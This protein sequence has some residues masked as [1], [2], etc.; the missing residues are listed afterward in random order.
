MAP[1]RKTDASQEGKVNILSFFK[2][3]SQQPS[4]A[5]QPLPSTQTP[6]QISQPRSPS[7]Q[8]PS[9]PPVQKTPSTPRHH[10][11][12]IGASDDE[13]GSGSDGGFSDDS[14]EDLSAILG[15]ARPTVV[16]TPSRNPYA[17]PRSKRTAVEFYSSPLTLI[18][19]HKFDLAALTSDARQDE[20]TLASSLK[21][22]AMTESARKGHGISKAGLLEATGLT[23]AVNEKGGHDAHKVLRAVQRAEPGQ[24]HTRYCFFDE[25][26][27]S[28]N[29]MPAPKLDNKSP[30]RLLTRA[31]VAAREQ[32]LVSGLPQ[33]I[34]S[35][36]G[37]MPDTLFEWI[38]DELCIQN[39]SLMRQEYCS[40]VRNCP[41][42][43][44]RLLSPQKLEELL[45]RLGAKQELKDWSSELNVQKISSDPYEARDWSCLVSFLNLVGEVA[46]HLSIASVIYAAQAC[47]KLSMDR[48]SLY[49]IDILTAYEGAI[50]RLTEIIPSSSWNSFV[51]YLPLQH[52]Y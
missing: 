52:R 7:P 32:H 31:T 39:S 37:S 46:R 42:Q 16:A 48:L 6:P 11:L 1:P 34:L 22:K 28:P 25:A 41:D 4:K 40:L 21:V 5:S 30:W 10:K 17:T 12:E 51:S 35:M 18:P 36:S 29:P 24:S 14:L 43:V 8:L 45:I 23:D 20:A 49:N 19:K 50:R 33:T 38:L 15:R 47:L 44:E 2:P 9:S 13:D 27:K 3:V 26:Y